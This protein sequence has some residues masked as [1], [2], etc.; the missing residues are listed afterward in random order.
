MLSKKLMK[1]LTYLTRGFIKKKRSH[2][3]PAKFWVRDEAPHLKIE[4]VIMYCLVRT[5]ALFKG[6]V[7]NEYGAMA[8]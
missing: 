3:E 2:S 1:V 6:V 4:D 8:A 5:V 7:I